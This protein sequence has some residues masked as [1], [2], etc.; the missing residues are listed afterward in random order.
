MSTAASMRIPAVLDT[1]MIPP[2]KADADAT[3]SVPQFDIAIGL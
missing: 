3:D 1:M 2:R